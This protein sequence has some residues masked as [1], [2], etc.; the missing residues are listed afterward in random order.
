MS[1]ELKESQPV[2]QSVTIKGTP[3]TTKTNYDPQVKAEAYRL[4]LT[5]DLT[6]KDMAIELQVPEKV[7]LA[8]A[9]DGKWLERK[10]RLEL[11]Y[12]LKADNEYRRFMAD[13]R[14]DVAKRHLEISEKIERAI[15]AMIDLA[16][17]DPDN[18]SAADLKRLAESLSSVTGVSSRAVGIGTPEAAKTMAL[19]Q[20]TS[21]GGGNGKQPVLIFNLKPQMPAGQELKHD[22]GKVVD[23]G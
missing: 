23:I 5:T 15:G 6:P 22:D 10:Q 19:A 7:I 13:R 1:D 2:M 21:E 17:K 20:Q 11:E 8:W 16:L 3:L 9:V 12:L 4:Y 14:P 18:M